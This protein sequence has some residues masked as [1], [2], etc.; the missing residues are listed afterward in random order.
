M[1]ATR[2]KRFKLIV[3]LCFVFSL[4]QRTTQIDRDNFYS[5][6]I[7]D[8]ILSGN[9]DDVSSQEIALKTPYVYYG[10]VYKS[11]FVS[12]SSIFQHF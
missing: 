6:G 5:Y 9:S 2:E 11:I 8:S 3:I 7:G 1:I 4:L 10:K 12:I